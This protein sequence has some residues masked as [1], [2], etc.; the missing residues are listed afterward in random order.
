MEILEG[1]ENVIYLDNAATVFPKPAEVL[2][3]MVDAYKK[4]GVN[5]GR[6]GFDLCMVGG[7]FIESTRARLTTFFGGTAPE[8]LCFNYNASEALNILIQGLV[9]KG[10]HVVT[11]VLEHNSVIRPLNQLAKDG[12]ITHDFV[13]CDDDCR[14]DPDEIA[15][16]FKKNTK[17]VVVNHG[18]NVV[19]AIQ[20]VAE[21]GKLCRERGI[22]LVVDTAQ[23]AGV[24]PIDVGEMN[25]DAIAFTGHKSL[26][27]PGGI[28][29]CYVREG[30]EVRQTRYGGTGV[31]S[32]YPYHLEQY[33]FR[34]E[35]GTCNLIGIVGLLLAQDWIEKRG[36]S[37]IY[38]HEMGLIS[39]L[40]EALLQIEGV[41]VHGTTSLEH[42]LPVVSFSVDGQDAADTGTMLDVDHNIAT[43]T[44]LHCAPLIHERLGTAPR[45]TVRMSMGP[46]S[47]DSDIDAAIAAVTEIAGQ[48]R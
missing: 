46:M 48:R 27:G 15:K 30:L 12:I 16:H 45:G 38:R 20:P 34:L 3:G 31:E 17:L 11:T 7:D 8:R 41:T 42:R 18:S 35:V 24:V 22:T 13:T 2:D 36:M 19:G 32:A 40:Q 26:L 39:R 1:I 5:P 23:T 9:E 29:G 6:S 33:P 47:V 43:R 37:E 44:G 28:G 21:I 10:D 25:I 14:V 4:Y